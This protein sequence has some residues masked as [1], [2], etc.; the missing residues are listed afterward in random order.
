VAKKFIVSVSTRSELIEESGKIYVVDFDSGSTEK[1]VPFV[2]P[3]IPKELNPSPHGGVRGFRGLAFYDGLFYVANFDSILVY[4]SGFELFKIL[5]NKLFGDLHGLEIYDGVLYV[6][7]CYPE[8]MVKVSLEGR[9][10]DFWAGRHPLNN[11]VDYRRVE[12]P[13]QEGHFHY[14]SVLKHTNGDTYV[15]S[16]LRSLL[17]NA[18]RA[19]RFVFDGLIMPHD[20]VELSDGTIAINNT[21]GSQVVTVRPDGSGYRVLYQ[22]ERVVVEETDKQVGSNYGWLRGL[23]FD[24]KNLYVGSSPACIKVVSLNG[25]LVKKIQLSEDVREAP[26]TVK[27]V[28][29]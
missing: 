19:K 21:N 6:V 16:A 20:L 25:D 18:S 8:A 15:L 1:I 26:F 14:N 5:T 9:V 23:D 10:L 24:G 2:R 17:V 11:G 13:K 22:D 7:C 3:F 27:V 12:E 29:L 4:D 28:D